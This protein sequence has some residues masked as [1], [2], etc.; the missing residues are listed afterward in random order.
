MVKGTAAD[1]NCT[2]ENEKRCV[3]QRYPIVFFVCRL[4]ANGCLLEMD[5]DGSV[6]GVRLHM[7]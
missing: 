4:N 5:P 3:G 1:T 2:C 6:K 7:T